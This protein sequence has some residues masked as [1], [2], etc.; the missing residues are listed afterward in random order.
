MSD[1]GIEESEGFSRLV[2]AASHQ[3][4]SQYLRQACGL[5]QLGG[6]GRMRL[7][8]AP[9]LAEEL[10][11]FS[12]LSGLRRGWPR[13]DPVAVSAHRAYSSSSL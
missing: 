8:E 10:L 4:L 13:N 9:A 7:R 11:S 2:N 1:F 3:Q 12:L 5:G 6:L